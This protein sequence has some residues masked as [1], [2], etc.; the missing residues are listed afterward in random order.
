MNP[1]VVPKRLGPVPRP[2]TPQKCSE[3]PKS[4][5]PGGASRVRLPLV[6]D[7]H[8]VC[9]CSAGEVWDRA[10]ADEVSQW[11]LAGNGWSCPDLSLIEW[12]RHAADPTVD[13]AGGT[14]DFAKPGLWWPL[15]A[16]GPSANHIL[17]LP[18]PRGFL[19][20]LWRPF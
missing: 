13:Q 19:D 7:S 17:S 11:G 9:I 1:T 4:A 2:K 8:K 10:V 16:W 18:E 14:S 15:L 12:L 5:C 20:S 3:T 6:Q